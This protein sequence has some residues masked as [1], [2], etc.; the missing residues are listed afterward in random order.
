MILPPVSII[1]TSYMPYSWI[2]SNLSIR[3]MAHRK[4]CYKL[5]LLGI[6]GP[7]LEWIKDFLSN[8]TQKVLMNGEKSNPVDVANSWCSTRNCAGASFVLNDLPSVIKS[9]IRMYAD[10]TLTYNTI[11]NINAGLPPTSM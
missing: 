10:D 7:I 5:S 3:C 9:K 4:L 1:N 2:S 11:H 8:R 6:R